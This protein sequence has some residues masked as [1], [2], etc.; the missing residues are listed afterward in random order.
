MNTSIFDDIWRKEGTR[1]FAVLT[2]PNGYVL[3]I[4]LPQGV[5]HL[6]NDESRI[7]VG[8]RIEQGRAGITGASYVDS[9]EQPSGDIDI[10]GNAEVKDWLSSME[11][12]EK[13]NTL[14]WEFVNAGGGV[15]ALEAYW[16]A[17]AAK[18]PF[19]PGVHIL[20]GDDL[21]G[22]NLEEVL[23]KILGE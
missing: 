12:G 9:N 18:S 13:L 16:D 4:E 17:Q 19:G 14:C 1:E 5:R 6:F 21:V 11:A 22:G 7:A 20:S 2:E 15:E 3:C 10:T 23:K 8:L